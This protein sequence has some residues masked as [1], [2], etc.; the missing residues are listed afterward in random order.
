[1][2]TAVNI[3]A[4][5]RRGMSTIVFVIPVHIAAGLRLRPFC[6]FVYPK[7]HSAVLSVSKVYKSEG[8]NLWFCIQSDMLQ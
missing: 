6:Q 2:I 3:Y 5:T 8:H 1:M 7:W 4:N